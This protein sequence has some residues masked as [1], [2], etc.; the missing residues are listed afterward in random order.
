MFHDKTSCMK[1]FG[2]FRD[3]R[4]PVCPL[5]KVLEEFRRALPSQL[6]THVYSGCLPGKRFPERNT[7]SSL[8]KRV[9][10]FA[11]PGIG[12]VLDRRR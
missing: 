1:Q 11:D 7:V 2:S 4:H 9:F 3:Y 8:K 5:R 12:Y 6:R 10:G